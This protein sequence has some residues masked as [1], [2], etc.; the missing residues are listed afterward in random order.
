MLELKQKK[1][2]LAN[3]KRVARIVEL[4]RTIKVGKYSKRKETKRAP[5]INGKERKGDKT[6]K[7]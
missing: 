2:S 3:E 7:G 5:K 1:K 6:S 4:C